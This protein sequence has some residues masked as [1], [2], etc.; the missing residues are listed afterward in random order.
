M[1]L[2]GGAVAGAEGADGRAHHSKPS[3]PLV[4]EYSYDNNA[5]CFVKIKTLPD[6]ATC[7]V[8]V[9]EIDLPPMG[10][11]LIPAAWRR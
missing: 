1:G 3:S 5:T 2:P 4:C 7:G 10:G 9:A 6:L 8:R 11:A